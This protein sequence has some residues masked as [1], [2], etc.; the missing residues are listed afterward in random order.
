M[1]PLPLISHRLFLSAAARDEDDAMRPPT[2][3]SCQKET[4]RIR[5]LPLKVMYGSEP[6]RTLPLRPLRTHAP[7]GAT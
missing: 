1:N 6:P 4:P 3:E 7:A 5:A 2:D